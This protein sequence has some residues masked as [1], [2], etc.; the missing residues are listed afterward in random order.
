MKNLFSMAFTC[1]TIVFL[2]SPPDAL[3]SDSS[4]EFLSLEYN[5]KIMYF[6]DEEIASMIKFIYQL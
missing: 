1:A 5:G 4:S 6:A 2:L 3:Q